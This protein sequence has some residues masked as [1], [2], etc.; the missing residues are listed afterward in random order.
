MAPTTQVIIHVDKPHLGVRALVTHLYDLRQSDLEVTLL[1]Q[2]APR[3]LADVRSLYPI[4]TVALAPGSSPGSGLNLAARRSDS[5]Y[6]VIVSNAR[7]PRDSQWL[8]H[9][10]KHFADPGVAAV[11]GEGWDASLVRVQD[12]SYRQD[13]ASF[14]SAPQFGLCFENCALRRDVW[15]RHAFD[16]RLSIGVDRHWAYRVLCEGYQIVLDYAARMHDVAPL[17]EEEAF[18]RYWAMNL[19]F[20]QFIQPEKAQESL[21]H[22]AKARA[23][24]LRN[25]FELLKALR[26]W[27]ALRKLNFWQPTPTQAIAARASFSRPGDKWVVLPRQ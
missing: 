4:S 16:E 2:D 23:W 27:N 3:D 13:L 25:P 19:S 24:R 9:L 10:L 6:L 7:V 11:S 14:L 22:L 12:P 26:A 8:Y 17:S 5:D 15:L 1:H 18:K 21:W 20:S